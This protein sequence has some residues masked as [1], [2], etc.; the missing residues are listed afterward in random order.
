VAPEAVTFYF[1]VG[2]PYAYLAATRVEDVLG[3]PVDWQPVLLGAI[4]KATGRSSWARGDEERRRR[5]IEEIER[6]AER[7]G[8]PPLR[9][10]DGWP[11]DYLAAMRVATYA[12]REGR[13]REYALAAGRAAFAE[14]RD[15]SDAEA[16]LDVAAEI[17]LDREA[18]RAAIAS[19]E[20]KDELR[21]ATDEAHSRG[22][23]GVPTIAVGRELFWGDDRLEEAAAL[24]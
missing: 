8:L 5:G 24:R 21:A 19:R 14:G 13:A 9:L 17:G 1:D 20:V 11:S 12:R 4:F 7:Y 2:S 18:T 16:A 3:A 10:P 23:F 15:L 22:V 6:R